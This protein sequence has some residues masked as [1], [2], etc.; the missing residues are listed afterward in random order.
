MCEARQSK[1]PSLPSRRRVQLHVSP[2]PSSHP[3]SNNRHDLH[4]AP[5]CDLE[6]Q[7]KSRSPLGKR[8]RRTKRIQRHPVGTR[9]PKTN[10]RARPQNAT[11]PAGI[12]RGTTTSRRSPACVAVRKYGLEREAPP[13]QSI[14]RNS[15][16]GRQQLRLS[17]AA[18]QLTPALTCTGAQGYDEIP[19][20]DRRCPA[21]VRS[22]SVESTSTRDR[23]QVQ[24]LVRWR[25]T[26]AMHSTVAARG[27]A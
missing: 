2:R 22:T 9:G 25:S 1:Q 23:C 8:P 3:C 6:P 5:A 16:L 21:D 13:T 18:P 11:E 27:S 20:E 17:L 26:S 10:Q 12:T 19:A 14:S 24:R 15:R 7:K 4:A